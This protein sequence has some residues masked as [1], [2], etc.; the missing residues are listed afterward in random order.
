MGCYGGGMS[1]DK[2][3]AIDRLEVLLDEKDARIG[4]L[5]K[6]V[7]R[8]EAALAHSESGWCL[9]S[10]IKEEQVLPVP[11]LEL[12]YEPRGKQA[13]R[14]WTRYVVTYRMVYRHLLG[15][16]VAVPL[17]ETTFS[18]GVS[19][20]PMQDGR[21]RLPLRDGAHICHDMAALG[22]PGFAVCGEHVDDLAAFAGKPR[23]RRP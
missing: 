13:G 5:E 16:C 21:L 19:S 20:T 15:H 12:V 23:E 11:R 10:E 8:L 17:G 14:E 3:T 4:E 7:E 6:N 1:E 22:M 18:G 9:H 2:M